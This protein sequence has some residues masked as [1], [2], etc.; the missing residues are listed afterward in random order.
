[1]SLLLL[2][3]FILLPIIEITLLIDIGSTIGAGATILLIITT[4][5]VGVGLV[6]HQGFSILQDAQSQINAGQ[7]PAKALA[8]GIFVLLAGLMLIIPGFLT[9]GIGFLLL[10]PP[11]R[12]LLL[13][14]VIGS[15][16]TNLTPNMFSAR[17]Y[18]SASPQ[19]KDAQKRTNPLNPKPANDD[20]IDANHIVIDKN[21]PES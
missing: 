18:A 14:F 10:L 12:S 6:R 3:F 13:E 8:H 1:M 17:F 19:N 16:V 4:A 2:V 7:P 5:V 15:I 21:D 20:V 9:D 11:V